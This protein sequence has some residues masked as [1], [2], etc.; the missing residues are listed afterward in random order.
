VTKLVDVVVGLSEK[1]LEGVRA[2][3]AEDV[4]VQ[5]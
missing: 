2:E 3:D 5:V 1:E 4:D